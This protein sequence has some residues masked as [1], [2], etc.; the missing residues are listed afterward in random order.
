M[1]YALDG[2]VIGTRNAKFVATMQIV[3][4]AFFVLLFCSLKLTFGA[5]I[6]LQHLW[7]SLFVFQVLR[8]VEHA[9]KLVQDERAFGR[10]VSAVAA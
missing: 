7:T 2:C 9:W 8:F 3:N 4:T 6:T 5:A 1:S 10:R